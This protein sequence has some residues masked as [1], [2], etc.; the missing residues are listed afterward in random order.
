MAEANR[1]FDPVDTPAERATLLREAAKTF[2][3]TLI[4]T[5]N[6]EQSFS[7][8]VS[9]FS[10]ELGSFHVSLPKDFDQKEFVQNIAKS[11][12]RD[13]LFSISLSKANIFFKAPLIGFD[14]GIQ[15]KT[16][17]EIFKIQR[18][19]FLRY[20]VP[21][22]HKLKVEFVDPLFEDQKVETNAIDI[23]AGGLAVLVGKD[24]APTYQAQLIVRGLTFTVGG[25]QITCDAEVRHTGPNRVN[26]QVVGFKIGFLFQ[27]LPQDM[28]NHINAWVMDQTRKS[29]QSFVG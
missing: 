27:N 11:G 5:K 23:S 10:E 2:A 24:E 17:T 4:W 22:S 16:P 7:T 20:S 9:V 3:S 13:L 21:Q 15:F 25:K 1:K 6:Q 29:F 12:T 26:D 28:V 19:S 8:F 18:R 14:G